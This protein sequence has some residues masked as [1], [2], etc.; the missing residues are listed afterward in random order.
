MCLLEFAVY[1]A[2]ETARVHSRTI[3]YT[4]VYETCTRTVYTAVYTAA[5]VYVPWTR[6][7][8]RPCTSREHG[9]VHDH[10]YDRA[11]SLHVYTAHTR[12]VRAVYRCTR[13]CTLTC[14]GLVHGCV[15]GWRPRPFTP[16]CTR[17][18]ISRVHGL[19]QAVY[20]PVHD[21][22]QSSLKCQKFKNPIYRRPTSWKIENSHTSATD[23]PIVM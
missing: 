14:T 9:R 15:R 10:V 7:S 21:S 20:G 1:A 12:P 5:A 19:I 2:V 16:S 23:W 18:C 6:S 22:L 11:R 17:P 3:V 13:P 8:T 4:A